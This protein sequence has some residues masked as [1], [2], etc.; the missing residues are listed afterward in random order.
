MQTSYVCYTSRTLF[1]I[2]VFAKLP[3]R[4]NIGLQAKSTSLQA[5]EIRAGVFER[6]EESPVSVQSIGKNE[7]QRNPGG[8][9][10]ISRAIQILP[11]VVSS[12][13]DQP[14][15]KAYLNEYQISA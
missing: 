15:V 6:K 12:I 2:E 3:T 4:L 5:V 1:E 11:G 7:I 8:N 9:R 10:D 13:G 14:P